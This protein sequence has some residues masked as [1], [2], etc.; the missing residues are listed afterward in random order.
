[1]LNCPNGAISVPTSERNI[2]IFVSLY[3]ESLMFFAS[4]CNATAAPVADD[5]VAW[6]DHRAVRVYVRH[7]YESPSI[8]ARASSTDVTNP[9]TP[10]RLMQS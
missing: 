8:T 3:S 1:M 4:L 7:R 10:P 2:A 6:W 5:V 9:P